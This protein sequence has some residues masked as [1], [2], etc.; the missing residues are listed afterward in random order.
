MLEP[1]LC[2]NGFYTE[3]HVL[4]ILHATVAPNAM[5]VSNS[6]IRKCVIGSKQCYETAIRQPGGR[7]GFVMEIKMLAL[8]FKGPI[9]VFD[10]DIT[11]QMMDNVFIVNHI[12]IIQTV[13]DI[14][15]QNDQS[16]S[17]RKLLLEHYKPSR[18][19]TPMTQGEDEMAY[20]DRFVEAMR[21]GRHIEPPPSRFFSA[22]SITLNNPVVLMSPNGMTI[23]EGDNDDDEDTNFLRAQEESLREADEPPPRRLRKIA[24]N[25]ESVLRKEEVAQEGDP[26]CITCTGN[27]ASIL[28]IDCGHQCMCDECVRQMLQLQ[29]VKRN[30]PYCREE[31]T[32]ISRPIISNKQG[33]LEK[34]K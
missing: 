3:E 21:H 16:E 23:I 29:G 13:L 19:P 17:L 15:V 5:T 9:L 24:P 26:V 31:F 4:N 30:C 14:V 34:K 32:Q 22:R 6:H 1:L 33:A 20:A 11:E 28:F 2:F 10:K 25:M 18:L 8:T 27:R 12:G 7:H